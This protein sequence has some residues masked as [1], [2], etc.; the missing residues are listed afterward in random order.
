MNTRFEEYRRMLWLRI[1]RQLSGVVLPEAHLVASI[2][3]HHTKDLNA[4]IIQLG[5]LPFDHLQ[6]LPPEVQSYITLVYR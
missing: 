1:Y 5:A 4:S 3:L 2:Q 6:S